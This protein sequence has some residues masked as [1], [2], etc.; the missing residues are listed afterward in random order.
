MEP[1]R[2]FPRRISVQ[3][4][5]DRGGSQM[6]TL[7]D[8]EAIQIITE[9]HVWAIKKNILIYQGREKNE[10]KKLGSQEWSS[11][12]PWNFHNRSSLSTAA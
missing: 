5:V 8:K 2:S 4:P 7:F 6:I 3:K 10:S 1:S 11:S 12:K 9:K